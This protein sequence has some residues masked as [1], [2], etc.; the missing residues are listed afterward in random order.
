MIH[1]VPS[2]IEH[3]LSANASFGYVN[4]NKEGVFS[5]L[6]LPPEIAKALIQ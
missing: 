1:E 2:K 6:L 3:Q 4:F 5:G